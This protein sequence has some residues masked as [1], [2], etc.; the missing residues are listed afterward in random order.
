MGF[1]II[2]E[3]PFRLSIIAAY[4]KNYPLRSI[5]ELTKKYLQIKRGH[6]ANEEIY[7]EVEMLFRN[8]KHDS[9]IGWELL[10]YLAYLDVE[11]VP[12][13]LIKDIRFCRKDF[14]SA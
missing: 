1:G 2:G 11:G 7:P 13:S 6:S 8:L 3:S 5:D 9:P 12:V 4:V 14:I 10:K